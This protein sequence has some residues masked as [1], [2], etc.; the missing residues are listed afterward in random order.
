MGA[1]VISSAEVR[2]DEAEEWYRNHACASSDRTPL[3]A[4]TKRSLQLHEFKQIEKILL[5]ELLTATTVEEVNLAWPTSRRCLTGP[6]HADRDRE[7][8]KAMGSRHEG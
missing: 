2:C 1:V 4:T 8:I 3:S 7:I 6:I 5:E